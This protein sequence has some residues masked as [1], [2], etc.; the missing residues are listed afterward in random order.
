MDELVSPAVG[1][2]GEVELDSLGLGLFD[3]D[4]D[5]AECFK[6]CPE[7]NDPILDTSVLDELKDCLSEDLWSSPVMQLSEGEFGSQ[8]IE[9]ATVASSM[10][11]PPHSPKI[12]DSIPSPTPSLASSTTSYDAATPQKVPSP[13]NGVE[14]TQNGTVPMQS[15]MVGAQYPSL[16]TMPQTTSPAVQVL[17]SGEV[18][19]VK[20]TPQTD[21]QQSTG[22]YMPPPS[23]STPTALSVPPHT[24]STVQPAKTTATA[25]R[26]RQHPDSGS[27]ADTNTGVTN[28]LSK[29]QQRL[30]K[31][32][33]AASMSRQKKKEV[34]WQ[35]G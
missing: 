15:S 11:T 19:H 29:K 1:N 32:R 22:V 16:W 28:Q 17:K 4:V 30:I 35:M 25:T 9:P 26:K 8:S 33:E 7:W 21:T 3:V 14:A 18:V 6:D 27:T 13:W 12:L 20:M 5:L 23:L 2:D 34:R 24:Q 10:A 31:N